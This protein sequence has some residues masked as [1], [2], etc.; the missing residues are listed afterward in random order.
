MKAADI[1][2]TIEAVWRMESAK[3]VGVLTRTVR[4]LG[5]AEDFAQDA[6]LAAVKQW[7]ETGVPDNPGAWLMTIARRRAID[8]I[9]K[10]KLL[11]EKVPLIAELSA[12]GP[13][14]VAD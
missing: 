5:L 3:L 14:E 10:Q 4:D 9:R 12:S 2:R 6:L 1:H 11:E 13:D 8:H 7:P